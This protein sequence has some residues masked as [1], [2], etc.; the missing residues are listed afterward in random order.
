MANALDLVLQMRREKLAR[1]QARNDSIENA[2]GAVSGAI[3]NRRRRQLED[4]TLKVNLASKGLKLTRDQ[5]GNVSIQRDTSFQDPSDLI[6]QQNAIMTNMKLRQELEDR[7]PADPTQTQ[8]SA[9]TVVT[10]VGAGSPTVVRGGSITTTPQQQVS[11]QATTGQSVQA[12]QISVPAGSGIT[13]GDVKDLQIDAIKE[14]LKL[15]AKQADRFNESVS[16]ISTGIRTSDR[17]VVTIAGAINDLARTYA[18]G[19]EEGGLGSLVGRGKTEI[20]KRVGGELSDQVPASLAFDGKKVEVIARMMPLLTQQGEKEGSVRLVESVFRKLSETLPSAQ[21]GPVAGANMMMESIRNAVR[22]AMAI[23]Q[24]DLDITPNADSLSD[25]QIDSLANSTAD[26]IKKIAEKVDLS[27]ETQAEI[28]SL[29]I[30]SLKP[31]AKVLIFDTEEEVRK[32]RL[33]KGV[34]I[35]Y[36]NR[37]ARIT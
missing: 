20:A 24:G 26:R 2:F 31:M 19:I 21:T 28:D 10:N 3:E 4:L 37:P 1:E 5:S 35:T 13:K 33:P 8:A 36:Q 30:A 27:E 34:H 14:Q 22:F 11:G 25:D 23:D 12:P 6:A 16:K 17:N 9:Q 15:D 7:L 18:D 32:S 29:V